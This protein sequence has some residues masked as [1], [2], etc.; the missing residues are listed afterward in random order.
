M[1]FL[2]KFYCFAGHSLILY[3][4]YIFVFIPQLTD[5]SI[6]SYFFISFSKLL[7]AIAEL[8]SIVMY[9]CN[10]FSQINGFVSI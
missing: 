9:L 1:F 10:Y 6:R 4:N 2:I 5:L 8:F 3:I 7:N